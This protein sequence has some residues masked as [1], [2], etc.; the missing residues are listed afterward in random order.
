MKD[1]ILTALFFNA[2]E[3]KDFHALSQMLHPQFL[4]YGPLPDP[5]DKET[6]LDFQRA[7][8]NAFPDWS[9]NISKLEKKE[10]CTEATVQITGSNLKELKLP[11]KGVKPIPPTGKRIEMPIEHAWI[12]CEGDKIK[13]LKVESQFHGSLPGL[14]EQL[15]VE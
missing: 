10:D 7:V 15:G 5:F 4:Y 6:W 2:I 9:Y 1:I 14:L 13:E 3:T 8:Q 11:L 12:K